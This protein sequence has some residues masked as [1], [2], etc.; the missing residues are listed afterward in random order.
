MT[1]T[2]ELIVRGGTVVNHDGRG[3][4]DR[5]PLPPCDGITVLGRTVSECYHRVNTYTSEVKRQLIVELLCAAKGTQPEY[6]SKEEME[7]MYAQGDS[8]VYPKLIRRERS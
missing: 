1:H 5:A 7:W 4:R 6:M 8:V 3:A 2:F